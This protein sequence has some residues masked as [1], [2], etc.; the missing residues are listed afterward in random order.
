MS[1]L[2]TWALYGEEEKDKTRGWTSETKVVGWGHLTKRWLASAREENSGKAKGLA[3]LKA[4]F[5]LIQALE[6]RFYI[7]SFIHN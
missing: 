5:S 2:W 6:K 4:K 7:I 3:M 1:K